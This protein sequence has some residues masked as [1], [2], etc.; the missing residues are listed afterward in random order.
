V[1]TDRKLDSSTV[2]GF[3]IISSDSQ[4]A[5]LGY[6]GRAELNYV[7]GEIFLLLEIDQHAESYADEV[8]LR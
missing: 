2:H 4:Q 8:T 3:P 5:L 1:P 6:I 7:L